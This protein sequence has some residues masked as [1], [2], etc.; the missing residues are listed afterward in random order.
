MKMLNLATIACLV[1]IL[2][3]I[4]LNRLLRSKSS[5]KKH[6]DKNSTTIIWVTMIIVILVAVVTPKIFVLPIY[7]KPSVQYVGVAIIFIAIIFRL[8]V[9]F[10]LGKFFTVDVT[11]RK[12][13]KLK[14]DGLYK[15]L[16]HPAYFASLMSFVGMGWTF[17]N[18]ISLFLIVVAIL[19][20]LIHRI[21]V[22]EKV[23]IHHFGSEY[24][25]YQKVTYRIIP[26]IY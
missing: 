2:T 18:W 17:N 10:T 14:K 4:V 9:V 8:V 3:E 26:F 19:I 5:D 22:E 13:H 7:F 20:V 21:N 11:I 6:E 1:L 16:R 12:D 23:L 25:E 15:Y 24:V